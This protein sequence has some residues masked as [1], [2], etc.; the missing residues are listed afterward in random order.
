MLNPFDLYFYQNI[1]YANL[2]L[3][4]MITLI[5]DPKIHLFFWG[6][7]SLYYFFRRGLPALSTKPVYFFA[8]TNLIMLCCGLIKII[9]GRARPFLLDENIVGFTFFTVNN[10][11]LSFPSSHTA[12]AAGLAYTLKNQFRPGRLIYFY[13]LMI[14][15]TRLLLRAHFA[16]DVLAGFATGLLLSQLLEKIVAISS[17]KFQSE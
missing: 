4:K 9:F 6:L 1:P 3:L 17:I 7:I 5:A 15:G 16:T 10:D 8:L 11:F 2:F 14:M 12:I 13:P